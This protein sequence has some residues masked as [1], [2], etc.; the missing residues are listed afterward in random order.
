[1]QTL[2]TFTH[3]NFT[4]YNLDIIVRK[5]LSSN[6]QNAIATSVNKQH[7]AEISVDVLM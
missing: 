2:I 6:L 7:S 3:Y 4:Y 5:S 1:M